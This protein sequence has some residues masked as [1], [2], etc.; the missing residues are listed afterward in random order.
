MAIKMS[1]RANALRFICA[2]FLIASSAVYGQDGG[3][4]IAGQGHTLEEAVAQAVREQRQGEPIWIVASDDAALA[5]TQHAPGSLR[6]LGAVKQSGGQL[7]VCAASIPA[8]LHAALPEGV[9]LVA[10]ANTS[11]F[12]SAGSDST[13][14]S[15]AFAVAPP[16]VAKLAQ[17]TEA[18]SQSEPVINFPLSDR[19]HRLILSACDAFAAN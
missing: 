18:A 17:A 1:A 13:V 10:P 14:A 11:V 16:R 12:D 3:L 4:Y 9:V 15:M 2:F 19:Q 5:I 7:F 8:R 6:A